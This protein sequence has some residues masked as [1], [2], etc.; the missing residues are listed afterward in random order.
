MSS[1][2]TVSSGLVGTIRFLTTTGFSG[3]AV[4]LVRAELSRSGQSETVTL[5][6]RVALEVSTAPSPDFDGDGTVGISD[7]LQFVNHFGTSRGG[8]GY[9]A[10]YD[11][12]GNDVIGISD[13]LI[14]VNNF[15]SQVP[16]SWR[17]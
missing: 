6:A 16:P 14:F 3:T 11:L 12:D 15:G 2:A 5:T 8:A 17:W 9:D 4:Q 1:Q 10:K 13:F 7:F